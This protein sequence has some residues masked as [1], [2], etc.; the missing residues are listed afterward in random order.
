MRC[1]SCSPDWQERGARCTRRPARIVS[2]SSPKAARSSCRYAAADVK[3][4]QLHHQPGQLGRWLG[5]QAEE[6]GVELPGFAARRSSITR[7]SVGRRHRRH[8]PRRRWPA[9]PHAS[10]R[11]W[12]CMP[13]RPFAEGC[14]GSA[15]QACSAFRCAMVLIR[16]PTA[17]AS[18]SCGRSTG[19]ASAGPDRAHR[20]LADGSKATPMAAHS[21]YHLENNWSRPGLAVGL[22]LQNP[23]LSPYEEFQR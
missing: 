12:S 9:R 2:C 14:C 16:K 21:I 5:E 4:R 6:L 11:A 19:Q 20:R 10:S 3:P 1:R 17:S 8:G 23:W 7:W 15:D 22:G 18:R 13:A